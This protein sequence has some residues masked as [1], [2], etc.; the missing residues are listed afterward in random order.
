MELP[1]F[2]NRTKCPCVAC[3]INPRQIAPRDNQNPNEFGLTTAKFDHELE[4][5]NSSAVGRRRQYQKVHIRAGVNC[6][7]MRMRNKCPF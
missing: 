2:T 4:K 7:K 6:Q 1:L 5:L 3:S